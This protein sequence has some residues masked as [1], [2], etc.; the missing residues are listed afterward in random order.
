MSAGRR[1]PS[2][3]QVQKDDGRLAVLRLCGTNPDLESGAPALHF[4]TGP[5]ADQVVMLEKPVTTLGSVPGNDLVI[6]DTSV[7]RKHRRYPPRGG[8]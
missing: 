1:L 7:S 2:L 8:G 3:P 6:P 5:F 4:V